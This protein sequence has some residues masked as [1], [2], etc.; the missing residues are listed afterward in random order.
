MGFLPTEPRL[1]SLRSMQPASKDDDGRVVQGRM[2]VYPGCNREVCTQGGVYPPYPPWYIHQ[3]TPLS[4]NGIYTR[5]HLSPTGIPQEIP[6]PWVYHR[7]DTSHTHG[8]TT[9]CTS[10]HPGFRLW[11]D[12]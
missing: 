9:G 4:P 6:H 1:F 10:H 12:G 3:G 5:V 11:E 2:E 8:Y 7:G